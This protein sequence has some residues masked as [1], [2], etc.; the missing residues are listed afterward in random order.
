M[1][2]YIYIR[3][4]VLTISVLDNA[5]GSGHFLVNAA[6]HIA[7]KIY[8]FIHEYINFT[9]S[10]LEDET[11]DFSYWLKKVYY[12]CLCL[13]CFLSYELLYKRMT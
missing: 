3:T 5:M 13:T 4:K 6:Y 10:E 1:I 11:Y 9:I 12:Y 2:V 8:S 7:T